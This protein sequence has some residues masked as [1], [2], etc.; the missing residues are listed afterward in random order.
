MLAQ[1]ERHQAAE[2]VQEAMRC[3]Q[4]LL[5]PLVELDRRQQAQVVE[6]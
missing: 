4:C 1:A 3:V 5:V 6:R 2:A